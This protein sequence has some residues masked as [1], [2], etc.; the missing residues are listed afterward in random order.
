[1]SVRLDGDIVRLAGPCPVEDAEPLLA[2]LQERPHAAVDVAACGRMHAAVLQVLLAADRPVR[3]TPYDPF[4]A[5]WM[6]S[7]LAAR[8]ASAHAV[9]PL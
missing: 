6:P 1:M 2:L 8:A 3:G 4:L 7:L 9:D 5:R